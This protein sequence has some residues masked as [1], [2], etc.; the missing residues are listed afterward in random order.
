M[1]A[2]MH[3][4]LLKEDEVLQVRAIMARHGIEQFDASVRLWSRGKSISVE[5]PLAEKH[6]HCLLDIARALRD[7]GSAL[8]ESPQALAA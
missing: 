3:M 6:L 5:G 7:D 2:V 1:E 8:P 4:G